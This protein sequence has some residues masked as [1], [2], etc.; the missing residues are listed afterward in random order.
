MSNPA[1]PGQVTLLG[2]TGG[3]HG[4]A[5]LVAGCVG[6]GTLL[7]NSCSLDIDDCR[8]NFSVDSG[9]THWLVFDACIVLALHLRIL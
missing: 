8:G 5:S 4:G 7:A 2:C 3:H 1:V 6:E 9:K